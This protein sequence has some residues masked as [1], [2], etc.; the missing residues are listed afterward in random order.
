MNNF[1]CIIFIKFCIK[2]N[3]KKNII[4]KKKILAKEICQLNYYLIY[5]LIIHE[6]LFNIKF[7]FKYVN[8]YK[9]HIN[10]QFFFPIY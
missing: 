3:Y 5:H 8:K 9:Y 4:N 7:K 6:I 10:T 2:K 1:V